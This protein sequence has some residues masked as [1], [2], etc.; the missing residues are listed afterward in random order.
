M[1]KNLL[2]SMVIFSIF[3]CSTHIFGMQEQMPTLKQLCIQKIGTLIREEPIDNVLQCKLDPI[4]L[5]YLPEELGKKIMRHSFFVKNA[6][7][8]DANYVVKAFDEENNIVIMEPREKT[9]NITMLNL[10]DKTTKNF[11]FKSNVRFV[12]HYSADGKTIVMHSPYLGGENQLMVIRDSGESV[13]QYTCPPYYS[14]SKNIPLHNHTNELVFF[15]G[16]S[17]CLFNFETNTTMYQGSKNIFTDIYNQ[18]Y[19]IKN[20]EN[21]AT[22]YKKISATE[23]K[24]V[25]RF[26]DAEQTSFVSNPNGKQL[27]IFDESK[28][29][30]QLIF[31]NKEKIINF[32][33]YMTDDSHFHSVIFNKSGTHMQLF[34]VSGYELK[35]S[36]HETKTGCSIQGKF[37]PDKRYIA[38]LTDNILSFIHA[39]SQKTVALLKGVTSYRF[40]QTWKMLHVT[41]IDKSGTVY[42]VRNDFT[43]AEYVLYRLIKEK[44]LTKSDIELHNPE[45]LPL[46]N[47]MQESGKLEYLL[48][49]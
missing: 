30:Y 24:E 41:H 36:L 18:F 49:S 4:S 29:V 21:N 48:M 17:F 8:V 20:Q 7:K 1:L 33:H 40:S 28:K 11:S 19:V 34:Y 45:M 35:Y 9:T 32:N 23:H 27:F 5:S 22:L 42:F 2:I 44:E 16:T 12:S 38:K 14:L 39:S 26:D 10:N 43:A 37:Y 6:W 25:C 47:S 15:T 3:M 46:Y 13:N 31:L